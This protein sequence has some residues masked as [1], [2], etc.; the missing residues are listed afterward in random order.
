[1]SSPTV[2][3]TSGDSRRRKLS[4]SSRNRKVRLAT[5]AHR[6]GGSVVTF[7]N[8]ESVDEDR[9]RPAAG[10]QEL[11]LREADDEVEEGVTRRR[12]PVLRVFVEKKYLRQ[13]FRY[14]YVCTY[15]DVYACCV[16][17]V[18]VYV[19]FLQCLCFYQRALPHTL[20][21]VCRV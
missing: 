4:R 11:G 7:R 20:C 12:W 10:R 13:F 2:R 15:V 21:F 14:A 6:R 16:T 9:P 17:D 18:N 8:E 5:R 19:T 3:A 1:M